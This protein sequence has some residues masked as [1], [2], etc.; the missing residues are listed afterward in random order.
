MKTALERI[1][2]PRVPQMELRRRTVR[3]LLPTALLVVAGVLLGASYT[4][5]YWAMTLHAPQY[6][7]GL[8]V[9]AYLNRLTGDVHE[10]DGLNHYIGMRPLNDAAQFERQTSAMMIAV[11]AGLLA[12]AIFIHNRWAALA[13]FPAVLF[14]IGFLLDLQYWLAT[15]GT[16]LDPKAALSSSIKPFV[17]P[18]LGVG[19]IGQFKTVATPGVGFWLAMAASLTVMVALYFHRRAYKPLVDA[20]KPMAGAPAPRAAVGV[21]LAA[22]AMAIAPGARGESEK[23][24]NNL[25]ALIAEAAPGATVVVP[26]GTFRGPITIA[27]SIELIAQPGAIIDAGGVGDAVRIT[28]PDV[29][30]RGFQ[31][32]STGISLDQ[33]NAGIAVAAPRATISD[34]TLED[35]LLGISLNG[36]A[37]SSIRGNRIRGK[38]LDLSRRGDGIR[39]FSSDATVIEGNEVDA[40]RD[41]VVWYSSGVRLTSNIVRDSRYGMHFMYANNGVIEDNHLVDNSV[42]VFL[43]YSRDVALRRNR[44][45]HNR[46]PSGYGIGLKDMD[47]VAAEENTVVGN[48]VGMYVDNSPSRI[49]V[50]QQFHRNVFAFNDVGLAFLP[51]VQRNQFIDN[52]FLENI[53]QV[54]ILGSGELKNNDFTVA[55]RGNYWSDYAGFDADGDGR[56][57]MPYHARSLFESLIDRE[58]KLRLFLYSPAQQAVELAS[59]AFPIVRPQPKITDA[60]PLMRPVTIATHAPQTG[61][62]WSL[63]AVSTALLAISVLLTGTLRRLNGWHGG[64]HGQAA[65]DEA[66]SRETPISRLAVSVD[67][68]ATAKRSQPVHSSNEANSVRSHDRAT[69]SSAPANEILAIQNLQKRFGRQLAVDSL[70]LSLAPGQA[71]ALWGTNGAGKT[72]I[73]KCILGLHRFQGV[74]RVGGHDTLRE[75]KSARRLIGYVSQELSFYDD[76]SALDTARLF[77][78]LKRVTRSRAREVLA[79]VELLEHA[80][81][82]VAQLSGGMKQRLALAVALLADP[83]I[84]L[85]DEPTS[86]LDAAARR[87][88]FDLLRG[89]KA[90][91]KTIVFTT[92]RAE[93]LA[94][95]A[96]RVIVLERGRVTRDGAACDFATDCRLRI[97]VPA[98]LRTAAHD[99]LA[100]AGFDVTRNCTALLVRVPTARNATPIALLAG[101]GIDVQTFELESGDNT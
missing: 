5:S 70:S 6:P 96:D 23:T 90:G 56:G 41:V 53:E 2:G 76:L 83:P 26:V 49:D 73:I 52:E 24:V 74:I 40:V 86:N 37:G 14:P 4:Q 82:R 62:G 32:R 17:P 43:M 15:F 98:E 9:H 20:R 1:L 78:A 18:V 85:L 29:T 91:G 55:G 30:F 3:Y 39:V 95:L 89:L 100:R 34:N 48:R 25:D 51:S 47:G 50:V 33:Q 99:A 67:V 61:V 27:K 58:P 84:L 79:Q 75:G 45:E 13:A 69:P 66:E 77:A 35:V 97:S 8:H 28:A 63:P 94:G 38:A 68:G 64:W 54:A 10:I 31:I 71:I 42:G 101:A 59:R 36:A 81:K 60:A 7:K 19:T 11:V 21:A 72:T 46:G 44:L 12:G 87:A 88:F 92:H 16:N 65:R 80:G 22:A 57:D 93:E